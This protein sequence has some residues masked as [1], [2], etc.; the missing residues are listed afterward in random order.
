M[1]RSKFI[2]ARE[3]AEKEFMENKNMKYS[4]P[5]TT[6]FLIIGYD[7]EENKVMSE[8]DVNGDLVYEW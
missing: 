3:K 7:K 5:T 6:G 8:Y 2:K 4:T 1:Q